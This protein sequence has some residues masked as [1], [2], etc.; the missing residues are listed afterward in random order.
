MDD[1]ETVFCPVGTIAFAI[2]I[3]RDGHL[4]DSELVWLKPVWGIK[5]PWLGQSEQL[6]IDVIHELDLM[7]GRLTKRVNHEQVMEQVIEGPG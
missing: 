7:P 4:V 5:S 2:P 3:F 1:R 6:P